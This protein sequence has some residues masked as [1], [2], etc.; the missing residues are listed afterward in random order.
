MEE[1]TK[2]PNLNRTYDINDQGFKDLIQAIALGSKATFTIHPTLDEMK[3]YIAKQEGK[4]AIINWRSL[5]NHKS[6]KLLKLY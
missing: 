4:K 5:L 2:N 6:K 1:Y 3:A